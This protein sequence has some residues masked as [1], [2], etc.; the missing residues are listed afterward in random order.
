MRR[1]GVLYSLCLVL[2]LGACTASKPIASHSETP[3]PVPT[4]TT[5][6]KPRAYFPAADLKYGPAW[7]HYSL[8]EI[9]IAFDFP[10]MPGTQDCAL[11]DHRHDQSGGNGVAYNCD[12]TMPIVDAEYRDLGRGY[13]Y[14][15]IG[16]DSPTFSEGRD[17][18]YTDVR[19]WY[20]TSSTTVRINPDQ[21]CSYS[22]HNPTVIPGPAGSVAVVFDGN[23][24]QRGPSEPV[25]SRRYDRLAVLNLP[26]GHSRFFGAIAFYFYD[27][28]N[29]ETNIGRT[30]IPMDMVRRVI[31]SISFFKPTI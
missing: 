26:S 3:S 18:W 14:T 1:A 11:D 7:K 20:R 13:I 30:R 16:A 12:E 19:R 21:F 6:A 2:S 24:S 22:V 29:Q 31:G 15:F 28:A 25:S 17:C 10:A 5:S 27:F 4:P 8:P 23:Q 9:G